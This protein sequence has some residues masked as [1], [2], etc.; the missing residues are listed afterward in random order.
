MNRLALILACILFVDYRS[1]GGGGGEEEK[2][3]TDQH[4]TGLLK[5]WNKNNAFCGAVTQNKGRRR[6]PLV[7]ICGLAKGREGPR[8]KA[9]TGFC[10][11]ASLMLKFRIE[12]AVKREPG[13]RPKAGDALDQI[14]LIL[15]KVGWFI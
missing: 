10:M 9:L 4:T 1:S 3:V 6:S 7:G 2:K 13:G 5:S 11:A 12:A 14:I 8:Q 15:I